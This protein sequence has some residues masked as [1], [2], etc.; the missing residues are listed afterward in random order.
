MSEPDRQEGPAPHGFGRRAEAEAERYLRRHGY[1]I[2]HRNLRLSTGELDLVI[3]K[4]KALA[5]VEVRARRSEAYGGARAAITRAKRGR[6][7]RLAAQYLARGTQVYDQYRFDVI[8][9]SPGDGG[10]LQ[11][12]HIENAFDL[13]V[14]DFSS[15]S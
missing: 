15:L 7:V 6:L 14:D 4:N 10:S 13:S 3:E 1:T 12:E 9:C 8:L 2:L 5:F 11:L